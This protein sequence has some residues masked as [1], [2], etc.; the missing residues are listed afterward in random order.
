MKHNKIPDT[1]DVRG[2]MDPMR[3]TISEMP[4]NGEIETEETISSRKTF[5]THNC[6]CLKEMQK[7]EAER[8]AI[9]R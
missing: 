1:R 4:N 2:S 6:S 9:Q 7:V 5:L 3:M 8:K